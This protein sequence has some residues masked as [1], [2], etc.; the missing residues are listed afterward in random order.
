MMKRKIL[1]A[2]GIL[3]LFPYLITLFL[4]GKAVETPSA[5]PESGKVI[6]RSGGMGTE[7]IDLEQYATGMA[8][9]Q[10][11]GDYEA[12]A[13]KAQI[14][15]ARTY[16]YKVMGDSDSIEENAVGSVYLDYSG[17]K[18]AWGDAYTG[19]QEKFDR[20]AAESAGQVLTFGGSLID[21]VFHRASAGRTRDAGEPFP[22]LV[23]AESGWDADMDGYVTIR[24]ISGGE[25][26][27]AVSGIRGQSLSGEEA[28][29]MQISERD[30]AG[31]V[32]K[33]S[34]GTETYSGEEIAEALGL[35]SPCFSMEKTETGSKFIVKGVGHGYGMSQW[36]ANHLALEGKDAAA[37]L[38]YYFQNTE[39]LTQP[40]PPS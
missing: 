14:I 9:A 31:Y 28:S 40:K 10:I 21:S 29:G 13:I 35:P 5:L 3:L 17:R 19:Y 32:T 38:S 34:A 23:S 37:I 15:L 18:K 4:T 25:I 39:I 20:A 6:L 1:A 33:I 30:G 26:A 16:L 8:A 12:E 27:E 22:Y 7:K 2:A 36:G 24:E 11:P